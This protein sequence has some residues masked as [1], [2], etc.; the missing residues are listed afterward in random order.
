MAVREIWKPINAKLTEGDVREI[1]RL[2]TGEWG[3]QTRLAKQFGITQSLVWSLVS[4]PGWRH[5]D[6][7]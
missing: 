1:R 4:G 6:G 3:D 2:Y 5:V 7:N